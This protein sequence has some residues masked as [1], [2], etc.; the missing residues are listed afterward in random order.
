MLEQNWMLPNLLFEQQAEW[1]AE[2]TRMLTELDRSRIIDRPE[3]TGNQSKI[4]KMADPL[5]YSGG[6]KEL[7]K[8]LETLRSNFASHKHRF[9]RGDPDQVKYVVSFL[10]TWNDHPDMTQRQTENTDPAEWASDQEEAKDPCLDDFELFTNELQKMY[11]DK[12]RHLN[13]ATKAMQEYEQLPNEA[14]RVYANRLKANWRRAGWNLI[15]HEVVLYDMAWAGLRHALKTKV[16]P[17][18]SSNKDRFDT[19]DQLFDCAAASEFK[20]DDKKPG[21]QRQQQR[22]TGESQKGGDKKRNFRPSISEPT[23]N[24]SGNSN[25]S[26]HSNNS[27][28]GNSKSGKS[29]K[30]SG[31]SRANLSPAPWLSKEIYE[32]RKANR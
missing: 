28:T 15:T 25:T 5:R 31:G 12:H 7:D 14:V 32:S 21:G 11:G 18:I 13:A 16:R 20:P 29:N 4:F 3:N 30:S 8:F 2:I 23:E 1:K 17:W 19:L 27:G 24:T 9:P 10:D 26:N 22:Q 6:A